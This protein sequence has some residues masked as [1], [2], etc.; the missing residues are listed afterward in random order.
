MFIGFQGANS[1]DLAPLDNNITEV[2]G[3][4]NT[5]LAVMRERT[6]ANIRSITFGS[7][8]QLDV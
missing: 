6:C 7:F 2:F 8:A 5:N 1:S 3:R 4:A